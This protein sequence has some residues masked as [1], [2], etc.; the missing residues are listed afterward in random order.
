MRTVAPWSLATLLIFVTFLVTAY[1]GGYPPDDK[2]MIKYKF[3]VFFPGLLIS[4]LPL[5]W[6]K[7]DGRR[8]P[9]YMAA[10]MTGSM[11]AAT[12]YFSLNYN[13]VI[14][15]LAGGATATGLGLSV[16]I[17]YKRP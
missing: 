3:A 12:T 15:V 9:L 11:A 14:I 7:R 8:S 2:A 16:V 5:W 13:P 6:E 1:L 17:L 4:A 10:F